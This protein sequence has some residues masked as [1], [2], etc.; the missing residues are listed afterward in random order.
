MP[1]PSPRSSEDAGC[2]EKERYRTPPQG[3]IPG[4]PPPCTHVLT[5]NP[6][7]AQ[8]KQEQQL[9]RRRM[10]GPGSPHGD[11]HRFLSSATLLNNL[12][13][14]FPP[15]P[16]IFLVNF[17]PLLAVSKGDN[18]SAL[19]DGE[20]ELGRGVAWSPP[21]FAQ[22]LLSSAVECVGE[23]ARLRLQGVGPRRAK[24]PGRLG[25]PLA[26]APGSPGLAGF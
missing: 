17:Y 19:W 9:E 5:L 14:T 10:L 23:G 6:G 18:F 24:E 7:T 4:G 8:Q 21:L 20:V 13:V 15:S 22:S 3:D 2:S 16:F 1:L 12:A 25:Y 11:S 26:Q